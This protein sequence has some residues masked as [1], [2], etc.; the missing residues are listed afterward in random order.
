MPVNG[1]D[2]G[3]SFEL[4]VAHTLS[5]WTGQ[6]FHRTPASGALRWK[7]NKQVVSDIVPPP[8]MDWIV[9][10]ECKCVEYPWELDKLLTH[11]SLFWKHWG[12]CTGDADRENMVPMM[13]FS[14]AYHD[15]MCAMR[16]DD[17]QM[18]EGAVPSYIELRDFTNKCHVAIFRLNDLTAA[19]TA[20]KFIKNLRLLHPDY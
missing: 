20:E 4:K 13:V 10:I 17:F 3:K 19:M 11:K 14:K 2:K 7:N 6:E 18:L 15:V 9:S 5:D 1:R 16:R 8:A 12:Q